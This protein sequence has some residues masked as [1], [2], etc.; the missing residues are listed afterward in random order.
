[1]TFDINND[2]P[3]STCPNYEEGTL[4]MGYNAFI[5]AQSGEIDS[6]FGTS[7]FNNVCFNICQTRD[8]TTEESPVTDY[9]TKPH[10]LDGQTCRACPTLNRRNDETSYELPDGTDQAPCVTTPGLDCNTDSSTLPGA[11]ST[12]LR[13]TVQDLIN[14]GLW[15]M[16]RNNPTNDNTCGDINTPNGDPD[17][18]GCIEMDSTLDPRFTTPVW[19]NRQQDGNIKQNYI[20]NIDWNTVGDSLWR[21]SGRGLTDNELLHALGTRVPGTLDYVLPDE[22]MNGSEPDFEKLRIDINR[23]RGSVATC[24]ANTVQWLDETECTRRTPTRGADGTLTCDLAGESG[25]VCEIHTPGDENSYCVPPGGAVSGNCWNENTGYGTGDGN[26]GPNHIIIEEVY[27]FWGTLYGRLTDPSSSDTGGAQM[28]VQS[29]S[30]LLSSISGDS[31]F[32]ACV[33]DKLNTNEDDNLIQTRIAGYTSLSEFQ[34]SDIN[35]LKRKL[36]KIVTIKTDEVS[37]CMSLL[38]LGQS[39][40]RTGVAD[41]TLQIGSLIFSIVGNDRIEVLNMDNDERIKLNKMIDELGP[42]IPQAIKNIIHVSKEYEA[43]ICNVPSNTTLLLERVYKDLYDKQ[44]N[45]SFDISPYIDFNSLIN[46]NSHTQFI[47]TII[48]LV[49]FAFM[50]MHFSNIIVAFLSRSASIAKIN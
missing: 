29:F 45:I 11:P 47:K 28:A 24:T 40:C 15:G 18:S 12:P 1:M 37:E 27:D 20:D 32:E 46:I 34:N 14:R 13:G 41:K 2:N 48:V 8:P 9:F 10:Y 49:V 39:I 50:F 43:R 30:Q 5:E 42:L 6:S 38:N 3:E 25:E 36:R 31:T 22:Y 17:G 44:T 33:N 23:G 21:R 26:F 35:Y 19:Y 7:S 4:D 16:C